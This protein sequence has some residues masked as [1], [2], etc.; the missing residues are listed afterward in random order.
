MAKKTYKDAP[1][2]LLCAILAMQDK[3]IEQEPEFR[4]SDLTV[5][6]EAGDGHIIPRANPTVQEYRALVK[7]YSNALKAY[8]EIANGDQTETSAKL[9]DIRARLKVVT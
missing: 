5:E 2:T 7:D 1:E 8:K 9:T 3:L 6:V 4:A